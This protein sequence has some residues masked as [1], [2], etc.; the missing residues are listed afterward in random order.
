MYALTAAP[1]AK[2]ATPPT[3][4][5]PKHVCGQPLTPVKDG[6][7][8]YMCTRCLQSGYLLPTS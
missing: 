2:S 4:A 6:G 8:R 7:G 5:K 1:T 3:T